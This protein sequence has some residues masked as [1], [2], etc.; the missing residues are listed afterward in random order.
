[1][2]ADSVNKERDSLVV[3]FTGGQDSAPVKSTADGDAALHNLHTHHT[4]RKLH[5]FFFLILKRK[6]FLPFLVYRDQLKKNRVL[7]A[8]SAWSA[9]IEICR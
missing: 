6:A 4:N 7:M 2:L 9:W 3:D 8:S 1:L 5:K